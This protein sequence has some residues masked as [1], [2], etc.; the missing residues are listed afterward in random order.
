MGLPG[1]QTPNCR[2]FRARNSAFTRHYQPINTLK[3][4]LIFEAPR[5]LF[6]ETSSLVTLPSSGESG[7]P[8]LPIPNRARVT[9]RT[10]RA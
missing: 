8:A 2:R 10:A 4:A 1:R 3:S 9:T 6:S 7:E 5:A